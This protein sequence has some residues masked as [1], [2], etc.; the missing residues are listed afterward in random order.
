MSLTVEDLP[1]TRK[2]VRVMA[3]AFSGPLLDGYVLSIIGIALT[4]ATPQLD[5]SS[6]WQGL[7]GAATLIGMFFG[8]AIFGRL[9]DKIG[10]KIMY[11]FDLGAIGLLCVPQF[12]VHGAI[13]LFV[14]RL[15]M[16]VAIGADY[17]MATS[18]VTEFSPR[19][20]RGPLLGMTVG[21]LFVGFIL[22]GF[23][24]E[25]LLHVGPD[26]W[27]WM[28]LSPAF[29]A[30]V[31]LI[32]R[33]GTPESPRW[34]ANQ[35]RYDEAEQILRD[36]YGPSVGSLS[37]ALPM[38]D[39]PKSSFKTV[40]SKGYRS[41][42]FIALAIFSLSNLV[43]YSM[44]VF[45]PQLLK[46]FGLDGDLS[47][48]GTVAINTMYLVGTC[49]AAG[50][51]NVIGRRSL[52]IWGCLFG[53]ISLAALGI[54]PI[55]PASVFL[56]F[57]AFALFNSGPQVATW[58]YP[59][60][61]FPTSVRATAMG[62][63]TSGT[64]ISSAIGVF[65]VPVALDT[66]GTDNAMF[67]SAGV[68]FVGFIVSLIWAPETKGMTLAASGSLRRRCRSSPTALRKPTRVPVLLSERR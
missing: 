1:L 45:T 23:V 15:L 21:A 31:F 28:L 27:R 50:L 14:W 29:L 12:F 25:A 34:L 62:L 55:T 41:R 8:G 44:I 42:F 58:I 46:S 43:L 54:V 11:T 56:L 5:I 17:P 60:E 32:L 6:V 3:F 30:F 52:N 36:M 35:G 2:Q 63:I 48:Y 59:N 37:E 68:L 19:R 9:T 24:G 22:G 51:S 38:E 40:F 13:A 53:A 4:Q 33:F 47:N 67:I 49:I 18:I 39:S 65:F 66:I 57:A 7:I 16:G 64:R 26:G 61:L 20:Y 10:R